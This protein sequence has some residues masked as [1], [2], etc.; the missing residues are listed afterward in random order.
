MKKVFAGFLAAVMC[1]A[2]FAGCAKKDEGTDQTQD[3]A[4]ADVSWEYIQ[5]KGKIVMG[6]DDSFPPMGFRDD[7]GELVG[8]DIDM[9]KAVSEKL[10]VELELQPIDWKTK[11]LELNNKNVDLLWNGFSVTP[12]RAAALTLSKPYMTNVQSVLVKKDSSIKT[13]ADLKNKKVAVQ[14]GSSAQGALK[15]MDEEL[16]NSITQLD[17]KENVTALNDVASGQADALAVDSV[18]AN[19]LISK[20]PNEFVLLEE[21]LAPEEYAIGF[22]KGDEAFKNKIDQAIEELKAEGKA[23]EISNK[24]FGRDVTK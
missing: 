15:E 12:E 18:V 24:W 7:N 19:Y 8:F 6:L 17:F 1:L 3:Q 9:A 10:G 22:R 16:Y 23:A 13:L 20:R 11:E 14:D 4:T 2:I 5:N 21:T